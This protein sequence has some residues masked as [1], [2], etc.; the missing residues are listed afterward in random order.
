LWDKKFG[1][2]WRAH[3][4]SRS[5]VQD[6]LKLLNFEVLHT[7]EF[8]LDAFTITNGEFASISKSIFSIGYGLKAVKRQYS[9]IPFEPVKQAKSQLVVANAGLETNVH[10]T[11]K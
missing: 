9:L 7:A 4:I 8:G 1:E 11:K 2:S 3:F 5:R 10:K 6:W